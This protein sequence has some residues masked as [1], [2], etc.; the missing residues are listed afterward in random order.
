MPVIGTVGPV[1]Q[2]APPPAERRQV[3]VDGM[4]DRI[5]LL[6][7]WN[8]PI[9][10]S[11]SSH[12]LHADPFDRALIAQATV[13]TSRWLLQ[14]RRFSDLLQIFSASFEN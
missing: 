10:K 14:T 3:R 4:R 13:E 6:P 5:R 12:L 11:L 9:E 1:A 8:D 2:L 7:G